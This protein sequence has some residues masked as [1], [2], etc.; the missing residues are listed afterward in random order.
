MRIHFTYFP[1][2]EKAGE[3][4]AGMLQAWDTILD[5]AERQ[6]LAVLPVL[7]VWADWND[8]SHQETWHRWDSNPFNVAQG[9]PAKRPEELFD[10]TLCRRL[11]L[12]RL[13]TF[14]R[15]WSLRPAIVGWEIFSKLDL[16][17]GATEE[18]AVSVHRVCGRRDPG[19]GPVETAG[20]SLAGRH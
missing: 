19:D 9:G 4:D 2:G 16:V 5:A 7:G 12:K 13:E 15:H 3:V 17:T 10:D 18:R 11:W 20:H 14:V 1:P 6:G 8:G